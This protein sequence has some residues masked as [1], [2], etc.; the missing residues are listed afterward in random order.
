M[1]RAGE[2]VGTA[3]DASGAQTDPEAWK[4]EKGAEG[5]ADGGG[6]PGS[7]T[8]REVAEEVADKANAESQW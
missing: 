1:A 2:E 3:Q 4:L 7:G 6:S 5:E 8:A